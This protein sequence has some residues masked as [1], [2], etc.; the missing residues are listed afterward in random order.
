MRRLFAFV[1]ASVLASGFGPEKSEAAG[2]GP[3]AQR[4]PKFSLQDPAGMTFTQKSVGKKGVVLVVTAPT[5]KESA[6][7]EKWSKYLESAK[8]SAK[9]KLVFIEDMMVSAFKLQ[10]RNEMRKD[11]E[12]GQ[13]TIVLLDEDGSTRRKLNA[14]EKKTVVLVYDKKGRLLH[15][16]TGPPSAEAAAAIWKKF[17][18]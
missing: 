8:G 10:A 15:A 13:E 1:L 14:P 7:Q 11:Y 4:L 3:Y 5:M 16:E 9:A 6:A 12:P 17:D 18:Q 2:A